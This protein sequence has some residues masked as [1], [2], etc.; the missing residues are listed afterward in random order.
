MDL[1]FSLIRGSNGLNSKKK[2]GKKK[3]DDTSTN[4]FPNLAF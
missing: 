4:R 2:K 3:R 1:F